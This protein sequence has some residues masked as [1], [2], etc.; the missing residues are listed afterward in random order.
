VDP[1]PYL[2][3]KDVHYHLSVGAVVLDDADNVLL[4]R[5]VTGV[6]ILPTGTLEVGETLLQT[7]ARELKEETGASAQLLRYLGATEMPFHWDGREY[8]KTILWHEQR[9]TA[10]DE[11]ER[12][13]VDNESDAEV[14][15]L[16]VADAANT[17][18]EQGLRLHDWDFTPV[19][20]RLLR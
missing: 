2:N 16:T 20:A 3:T 15:W 5:R 18:V 9:L 7:L 8:E 10:I 12:A 4:L 6:H 13:R 14:V 1:F 19:I 11:S 17:F